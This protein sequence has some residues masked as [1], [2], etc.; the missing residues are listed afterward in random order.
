MKSILKFT[1][2][3]ECPVHDNSNHSIWYFFFRCTGD[4]DFL[5]AD[6]FIGYHERAAVGEKIPVMGEPSDKMKS[7]LSLEEFMAAVKEHNTKNPNNEKAIKLDFKTTK[8][9]TESVEI[10]KKDW[11][12]VTKSSE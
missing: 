2:E 5:E 1:C 9:V 6:V 3:C 11:K 4:V 12:N 7:D 10:L 8:A